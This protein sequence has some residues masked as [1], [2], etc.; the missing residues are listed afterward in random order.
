MPAAMERALRREAAKKGLTGA[1]KNKYIYGAMLAQGWKPK[2]E[3]HAM[4]G[5]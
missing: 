1:R 2:R 4:E 5:K 3:R